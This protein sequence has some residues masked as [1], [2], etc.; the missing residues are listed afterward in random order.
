MRPQ[1]AAQGRFVAAGDGASELEVGDVGAGDEQNGGD[2]GE[3][4][5]ERLTAVA[6]DVAL[7][8]L[9]DHLAPGEVVVVFARSLSVAH[10]EECL[11][12]GLSLRDAYA[13]AELGNRANTI[14]DPVDSERRVAVEIRRKVDVRL[15][16]VN[17]G[18]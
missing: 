12:F 14:G 7:Q 16:Q 15:E 3:E 11:Q 10:G 13:G 4:D 17:R 2:A 8:R 9:N 5:E 6:G 1:H 18:S